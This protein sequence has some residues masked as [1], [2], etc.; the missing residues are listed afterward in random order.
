MNKQLHSIATFD[1]AYVHFH[2]DIKALDKN[3]IKRLSDGPIPFPSDESLFMINATK[4]R[5]EL[6]RT[7]QTV[8]L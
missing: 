5:D 8:N 1:E 2:G 7:L 4:L 6:K 3:T